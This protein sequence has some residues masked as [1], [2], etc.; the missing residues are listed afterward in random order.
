MGALAKAR[1]SSV[2][3]AAPS[4][5]AQESST[6]ASTEGFL[7]RDSSFQVTGYSLVSGF[8]LL[9]SSLRSGLS[10]IQDWLAD[11]VHWFVSGLDSGLVSLWSG[12]LVSLVTDEENKIK[13]EGDM[14]QATQ[15]V[16]PT[17]D[18]E[19]PFHKG[20]A[21][22]TQEGVEHESDFVAQKPSN[23][24]NKGS[25]NMLPTIRETQIHEGNTRN[26]EEKMVVVENQS[27][28]QTYPKPSDDMIIKDTYSMPLRDEEV[29][30][31]EKKDEANEEHQGA[32]AT[33][34]GRKLWCKVKATSHKSDKASDRSSTKVYNDFRFE[35]L[36]NRPLK[37]ELRGSRSANKDRS[38]IKRSGFHLNHKL[39]SNADDER[40]SIS[41][42]ER[43]SELSL[44]SHDK[45][46]FYL[47]LLQRDNSSRGF[48]SS[49]RRFTP[50]LVPFLWESSPGLPK[51]NWLSL[52]SEH[53]DG[54]CILEPPPIMQQQ[55]HYRSCSFVSARQD[56]GSM[57][58]R[59][60]ANDSSLCSQIK[61]AFR[62]RS[63]RNPNSSISSMLLMAP[64]GSSSPSVGSISQGRDEIQSPRSTLDMQG[65]L[66]RSSSS[67][68]SE[69]F[70]LPA[71]SAKKIRECNPRKP[72][73]QSST[74][75]NKKSGSS[76]IKSCSC[77]H[78]PECEL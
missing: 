64:A 34:E 22:S 15:Q 54:A 33:T 60:S 75:L 76:K 1:R 61:T 17:I 48:S 50:S 44:L 73:I 47:R 74:R 52:D 7:V 36:K 16:L 46:A 5:P 12:S 27:D 29:E 6:T 59:R 23:D 65:Q 21:M 13:D 31:S 14:S 3:A 2:A 26:S 35:E 78:M 37:E 51:P 63:R 58:L 66:V 11:L 9:V 53:H 8:G 4:S 57:E 71:G 72:F 70:Q 28:V 43:D 62:R 38:E 42:D 49:R 24:M 10:L 39:K 56:G 77:L 40:D 30:G 18:E 68:D 55:Q 32:L 67:S 19:T 25:E 20:D 41:C 45:Q 69:L